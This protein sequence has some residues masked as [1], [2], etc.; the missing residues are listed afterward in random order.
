MSNVAKA[1]R[2]AAPMIMLAC[3]ALLCVMLAVGP[4]WLRSDPAILG[5]GSVAGVGGGGS[6]L[7]GQ[8]AIVAIV[9]LIGCS[10]IG[11]GVCIGASFGPASGGSLPTQ[12]EMLGEHRLTKKLRAAGL[13]LESEAA[14]ILKLIHSYVD[15]SEGYSNTLAQAHKNLP[16][17]AA[18]EP[19][20]IIV[21]YLIAENEKMQRDAA[22]LKTNLERSKSQI[23]TL[24]CS[25]AEAEEMSLSDALTAVGNRRC[26]DVNLAKE[27]SD[28]RTNG[29]ELC[30]VMGDIDHFKR[31]ND[32][33]G[34]LVGDE[35]LKMFA[36]LL[37]ASVTE[38]HTVARYGG[39]EFVIILPETELE[40]AKALTERIRSELECK[41]LA[42]NKSGE[43]LGTVTASFGIA[44]LTARDTCA[45]LVERADDRLYEAKRTGRNRLAWD[46]S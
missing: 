27:V 37:T 11:I 40:D 39:E 34:H 13:Q 2:P 4:A 28:A 45:K 3:M 15:A 43:Q 16:A 25:L 29:T 20:R 9:G 7:G 46:G 41:K 5:L 32:T 10:L 42:I 26:F 12:P 1:P 30:L 38:R 31:I 8:I 33:F 22:D 14:T 24:R 21:K 18:A 36:R 17:L 19:V 44:A 35:I 23:A 6:G